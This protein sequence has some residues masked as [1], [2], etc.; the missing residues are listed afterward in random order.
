[1]E[2]GPGPEQSRDA[3]PQGGLCDE[4][5]HLALCRKQI[6]QLENAGW[7]ALGLRRQHSLTRREPRGSQHREG[8]EGV[9]LGDEEL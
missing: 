2:A 8:G 7:I 1:M 5:W 6:S 3:F 4:L 9:V